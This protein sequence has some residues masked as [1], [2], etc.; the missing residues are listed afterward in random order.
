MIAGYSFGDLYVNQ[1][2]ERMELIHGNSKRVVLIDW[3]PLQVS[4]DAIT[5]VTDPDGLE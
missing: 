5:D 2:I 4:D 3:W 1:I